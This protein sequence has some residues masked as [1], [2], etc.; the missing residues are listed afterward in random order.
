MTAAARPHPLHDPGRA[1]REANCSVDLWIELLH[2]LDLEPT[3]AL[4]SAVRLDFEGDQ[5]TFWKIPSTDLEQLFGIEVV[6]L[7]VWRP[8]LRHA[9]EQ[10]RRG[11]VVMPEV[12]AWWLPDTHGVSYR[13]EHAKTAIALRRLDVAARQLDYFHNAGAWSLEGEDFDGLFA[14]PPLPPYTEIA[15]LDRLVR[16]PTAQLVTRARELLRYHL[17][18]RPARSPVAAHRVRMEADLAWLRE[19][20][21]A[22]HGHAFNTGRQLGACFELL[23]SHL[24]WLGAHGGDGGAAAA[25]ACDEIAA[26][27]KALQFAVARIA[28][29]RREVALETFFDR[30]DAA[31]HDVMRELEATHA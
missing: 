17:S 31:W 10:L 7:S 19:E 3:A 1:W 23:G 15:K 16:L 30:L 18:R 29:N 8:L 6:E 21:A 12:D 20:P 11:R 24:R 26:T 14:P 4:G 27:A 13:V 2:H 9:E 5:Y 25:A 22:F 28:H